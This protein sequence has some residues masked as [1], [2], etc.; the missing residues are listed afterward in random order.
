MPWVCWD[1]SGEGRG[2]DSKYINKSIYA[3]SGD[4][5]CRTINPSKM[6]ERWQRLLLPCAMSLQPTSDVSGAE[7]EVLCLDKVPPPAL[8]PK[9]RS[10]LASPGRSSLAPGRTE[11]TVATSSNAGSHCLSLRPVSLPTP[12]FQLPRITFQINV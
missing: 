7:E 4:G 9:R 5:N 12:S 11:P 8:P 1:D 10:W 6:K 2:L 3:M